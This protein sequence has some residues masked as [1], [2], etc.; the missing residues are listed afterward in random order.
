MKLQYHSSAIR[1]QANR[2]LLAS[3]FHP[4]TL[5][6]LLV[7]IVTIVIA[8]YQRWSLG[9][10]LFVYWG[11]SVI[12]G[13]FQFFKIINLKYFT[14]DRVL[15]N[16]KKIEPNAET[17]RT[18]AFF[19]LFHYGFFHFVYLIF[20]FPSLLFI[21]ISAGLSVLAMFFLNHLFSYF[22]NKTEDQEQKKNIAK[23]MFE[24]YARI[25]PM[26]IIIIFGQVAEGNGPLLF[27]LTLK[28]IADL[29]M[30]L[31]EHSIKKV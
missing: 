15:L 12:I 25:I 16:G 30:H 3:L 4:S 22:T 1:L 29:I 8:L 23:V 17:K 9:D 6:L 2:N 7:N 10:L 28:T 21:K 11:Q 5:A 27:F 24:P 18:I 20:I 13:I 31:N 26:H 19:F 14:T